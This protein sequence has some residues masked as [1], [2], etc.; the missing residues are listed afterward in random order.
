MAI[1]D[2]KSYEL[3][4]GQVKSLAA[5]IKDNASKIEDVD[6]KT[7]MLEA[8]VD[9]NN[10]AIGELKLGMSNVD[11]ALANKQN[12][13]TAGENITIEGNTISA[14][15]GGSSVDVVQ[16][17]G[18]SETD[19]MSQ[20]ASTELIY[21]KP[22]DGVD[23]SE[24]INAG[25]IAI[26]T[27]P[28]DNASNLA[29]SS[30]V[31]GKGAK[32]STSDAVAIG[33]G[34]NNANDSGYGKQ[35][36]IGAN[37]TATGTESIAIG[38]NANVTGRQSVSIG[39][40]KSI[41]QSNA[42]AAGYNSSAGGYMSCAIGNSANA[43]G[44]YS[45]AIGASSKASNILNSNSCNTAIGCYS[46]AQAKNSVALGYGANA[47]TENTVNVS[48]SIDGINRRITGV[49]DGTNDT[50]VAT[51]GQMNTA[52][53]SKQDTLTAGTGITIEN[54]T[55][56]ASGGGSAI[57]LYLEPYKSGSVP[58]KGWPVL[59]TTREG[60]DWY[61]IKDSSDNLVRTGELAAML[62]RGEQIVLVQKNNKNIRAQILSQSYEVED[63]FNPSMPTD[64]LVTSIKLTAR[65]SNAVG[66]YDMAIYYEKNAPGFGVTITEGDAVTFV[67][68]E[69]SGSPMEAPPNYSFAD[70]VVNGKWQPATTT[71]PEDEFYNGR[72][73][74][75]PRGLYGYL[76]DILRVLLSGKKVMLKLPE[77]STTRKFKSGPLM[78]SSATFDS[79]FIEEAN[80]G[81]L[82]GMEDA[83]WIAGNISSG[84]LGLTIAGTA[85][86]KGSTSAPCRITF[87]MGQ[88]SI[89][90]ISSN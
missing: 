41:Y 87:S 40:N 35:V 55:I 13:L 42:L 1:E 82:S 53:E 17:V 89:S 79:Y 11:A 85:S 56:S 8:G 57:E 37:A 81:M 72:D 63:N 3:T 9:T 71:C 31:I 68:D 80:L 29:V 50:D 78:V 21:G 52:L 12:K 88:V 22:A 90:G 34:A 36:V 59:W 62:V 15:G 38:Y 49:A 33:N 70:Y 19:V 43:E 16:E 23:L 25:R 77:F 60:F 14:T 69:T 2:D 10:R 30:V 86:R 74:N 64:N 4:G 24:Y 20:K 28:L 45:I 6:I 61:N 54:N 47:S 18:D 66:E 27:G 39:S 51:V 76:Y 73:Y 83:D 44:I 67:A 84:N 7:D 26:G 32:V 58:M 48:N 5:K 75:T 65:V 46:K